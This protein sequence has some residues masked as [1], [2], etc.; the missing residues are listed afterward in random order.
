MMIMKLRVFALV[1]V[2]FAALGTMSSSQGAV[3]VSVGFAP[4]ALVSYAPPPVPFAGAIWTPGYWA[5][6]GFTYFWVPGA[7]VRPPGIGLYWTPPWWGFSN[8]SYVF[9]DGYWGPSVGFY[10]GINYGY[11]YFGNGYWG[12]RWDGNV[13]AYNTAVVRVNRNVVTKT[14]VDRSVLNK[15]TTTNR[16]TSFNGPGGVQAQPTAEQKAAAENARKSG[17]TEQQLARREAAAKDT[18]L[19]AK[20]NKGH[21]NPDAIREFDKKHGQQAKAETAGAAGA[22]TAKGA[23]KTESATGGGAE[24]GAA[25]RGA[26]AE[27]EAAATST[28]KKGGGAAETKSK[29]ARERGSTQTTARGRGT[30]RGQTA[31]RSTKTKPHETSGAVNRRPT[32]TRPTRP[33]FAPGRQPATRRPEVG[34]GRQVGPRQPS[35]PVRGEP[36]G[37]QQGKKKKPSKDQNGRP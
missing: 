9:Y 22:E 14:F 24:H 23:A 1:A 5:W 15:A 36:A 17:P 34:P 16:R 35:G 37:E 4:P 32:Y 26:D 31:G 28:N 30:E 3:F 2:V 27:H 7:W 29:A 25:G 19:H 20:E 21:V 6:N 11:G 33:Q 8:G 18:R 12:G 10:G 13:F